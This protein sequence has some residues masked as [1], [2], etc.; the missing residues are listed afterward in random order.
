MVEAVGWVDASRWY[1]TPEGRDLILPMV[2]RRFG[3]SHGLQSSFAEG[4][5]TGGLLASDA[6]TA[7]DVE[8]VLADLRRHPALRTTIRINPLL[9]AAWDEAAPP[10][11][12][13]VKPRHS[14]VLDLEGGAD[15][16]WNTRMTSKGRG[17]VRRARKLGVEVECDTTGKLLPLFY[18]MLLQSFERWAARQ[19]EPTW[20]TRLRGKHRDPLR[21]FEIMADRLGGA[22][23]LYVARHEGRPAAA[24]MVLSGTNA[25]N[26][27]GAMDA[28]VGGRTKANDLLHWTAIEDACR[29]GCRAYHMGASAPGSSL[30]RFKEKFGAQSVP[31]GEYI[32]ERLPITKADTVLRG[33]VKRIIGFRDV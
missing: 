33:V 27:R 12:L 22:F 17:S 3:N 31:H 20:L 19:N 6:V 15:V 10:P 5:G 4:H 23:R 32:I 24:V 29:S 14:H 11:G 18:E 13:L 30:A 9:T 8:M 1:V 21:K 16:V 26:T 2:R 25:Y 28:A 7:S